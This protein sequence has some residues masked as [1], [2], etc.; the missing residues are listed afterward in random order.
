MKA[1]IIVIDPELFRELLQLPEKAIVRRINVPYDRYG[2]IEIVLEN[3]GWETAEGQYILHT[4]PA[5]I[6]DSKIDWNLPK[7]NDA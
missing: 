3:V 7:E 1:A 5:T 2:I 6:V 4:P